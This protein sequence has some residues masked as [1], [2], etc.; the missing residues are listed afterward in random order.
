MSDRGE[1]GKRTGRRGGYAEARAVPA[2]QA[3]YASY[4]LAGIV[5]GLIAGVVFAAMEMI[6][7][8][9]MGMPAHMPIRMFASILLGKTALAPA[10][11]MVTVW[12]AALI[13]HFAIAAF[14]GTLFGLVMGAILSLRSVGS[15]AL[16]GVVF[17]T[18][19]WL[20]DFYVL[21][22]AFWP[23]F[24]NTVVWVQLTMHALF[25]GLP[26]GLWVAYGTRRSD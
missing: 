20:I 8:A 19:V 25:Y 13:S 6:G 2:T 22:P 12:P 26:L 11:P 15:L 18:L 21:A 23:W 10:T 17:G 9:L 16:A 1:S 5:G 24:A 3:L 7:A 14:W 4:L